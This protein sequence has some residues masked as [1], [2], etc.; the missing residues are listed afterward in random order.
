MARP[1]VELSAR[2]GRQAI[3]STHTTVPIASSRSRAIF[4][5]DECH[6]TQYPVNTS[7]R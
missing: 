2:S 6:H 3:R 1:T 4:S 5:G 7:R